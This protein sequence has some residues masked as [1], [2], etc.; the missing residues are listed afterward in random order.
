MWGNPLYRWNVHTETGYAWWLDLFRTV[1]GL[2]DIVRLDHFRGFVGY[3]EVPAGE[4]TA[5]NGRWVN[6]PG[7][8]YFQALKRALGDAS[9]EF[10]LSSAEVF[11]T[12]LPIIA[13]DLGEITPDVIALREQ[14]N[15]PGMKILLFA[16]QHESKFLPHHFPSNC[17]VYSGTHDNDTARGWFERIDA[18]ERDFAL[19]YLGIDGADISWDL[20]RAA[21]RSV[22]VFAVAPMQDL[23]GLGNEARMNY[24]SRANGNC[25][26]RMR[27]RALTENLKARLAEM[28]LL[29]DRDSRQSGYSDSAPSAATTSAGDGRVQPGAARRN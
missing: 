23:L 20:I 11:S 18:E 15:L 5:M 26:W 17:V 16:F 8:H 25:T 21:W 4:S 24:P 14:L 12:G 28:N 27:P 3:W 2:V 29:Y 22:A 10:T 9:M 1:L 13:E 19:R 6:G 7:D